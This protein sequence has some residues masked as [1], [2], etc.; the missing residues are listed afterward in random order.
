MKKIGIA[1]SD[2]EY[3]KFYFDDTIMN[4]SN[5]PRYKVW[6]VDDESDIDYILCSD[7]FTLKLCEKPVKKPELKSEPV[8]ESV[9]TIE[10]TPEPIE[11]PVETPKKTSGRKKKPTSEI[12]TSQPVSTITIPEPQ[13]Q[14]V[15][16][17]QKA[18]KYE[19]KVLE[20]EMKENIE[21]EL[22]TLLNK[23]GEEHWELIKVTDY[24]SG[25]LFNSVSKLMCIFKRYK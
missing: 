14:P 23:Y 25:T 17:T 11:T 20:V 22:E 4:T 12:V 24:K 5:P 21:S 10:T 13:S 6:Y 16:M 19:Y 1:K 9:T 18:I 3:R 8:E 7:V 2:P 15:F